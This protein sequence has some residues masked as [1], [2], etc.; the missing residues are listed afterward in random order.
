MVSNR[1][2]QQTYDFLRK[3]VIKPNVGHEQTNIQTQF[4]GIFRPRTDI[5]TQF[6]GVFL[7]LCSDPRTDIQTQFP[8]VFLD[9]RSDPRTD[10]QTQFTGVCQID[11][12]QEI[13]FDYPTLLPCSRHVG[14]SNTI[15][16]GN[17]I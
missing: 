16:P 3:S 7:D 11:Y 10:I 1:S 14:L 5:Q 17:C 8:G 9:L 13:A 2:R 12:W 15:L 6:T 4:P